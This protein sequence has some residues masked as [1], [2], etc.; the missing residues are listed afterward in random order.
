LML[1]ALIGSKATTREMAELAKRKLRS[2][3]VLSGVHVMRDGI[4]ALGLSASQPIRKE[5]RSCLAADCLSREHRKGVVGYSRKPHQRE[6]VSV[7][8][9][10]YSWVCRNGFTTRTLSNS[11]AS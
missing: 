10:P 4:A 2:V 3:G 5:R 6:G 8:S 1:R 11:R 9:R 7:Q